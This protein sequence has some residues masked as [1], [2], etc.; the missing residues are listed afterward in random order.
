MVDNLSNGRVGLSFASG[1]VM[2]DFLAFAPDSYDARYDR[3]YEG[4]EQVRSLWKG[5][6]VTLS[7]PAGADET[8][9]IFPKPVQK[10]LPVWITAAGSPETFRLAGEK[11]ANLLTHLLGQ[12]VEELKE[13]IAIYRAARR[14]AGHAGEGHVTLMIHTFMAD[15]AGLVREK[16]GCAF[17]RVPAKLGGPAKKPRQIDRAGCGRCRFPAGGHVGLAGPCL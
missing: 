17:S 1:W 16:V 5:E 6:S 9:A 8:V 4:I 15:D 13:K 11:G 3:L 7:N 10:E 12:T 14:E 2:N